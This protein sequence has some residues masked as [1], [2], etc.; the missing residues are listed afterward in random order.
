M[1]AADPA[2]RL[3]L[4][5]LARP[6]WSSMS[7]LDI[8]QRVCRRCQRSRCNLGPMIKPL[9]VSVRDLQKRRP[10]APRA[11]KQSRGG[12]ICRLKSVQSVVNT[13]YRLPLS[14]DSCV[15]YQVIRLS[16][17]RSS[18]HESTKCTKAA[19]K[20]RVADEA[21]KCSSTSSPAG[22]R[23]APLLSLKSSEKTQ[24][25]RRPSRG[26]AR[27]PAIIS[28]SRCASRRTPSPD[29]LA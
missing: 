25:P 16:L 27:S 22:L 1:S 2:A 4:P 3:T 15:P 23:K 8:A 9:A 12:S 11:W 21:P 19:R 5:R 6:P 29:A 24:H 26:G 10:G 18:A 7:L 28:P 20:A 17:V 14:A 13:M